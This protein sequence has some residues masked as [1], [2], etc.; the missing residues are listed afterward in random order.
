MA[1]LEVRSHNR[2]APLSVLKY[3]SPRHRS[4]HWHSFELPRADY[5]E[6]CEAASRGGMRIAVI[7]MQF[8]VPSE[9]FASNDVRELRKRGAE[10]EVHCLR[11]AHPQA[12][13][14]LEERELH[15]LRVEHNDFAVGLRGFLYALGRPGLLAR[16]VRWLIGCSWRKPAQLTKALGLLPRAFAILRGLGETRPDV[17]H[18]AWGHYPALVGYLVQQHSPGT[19]TSLSLAA[20][21]LTAE[22]GGSIEVA[23]RADFVR[24]L[25]HCNVPD[26]VRFT[27]VSP[28][29]VE[30][31]YDGIDLARIERI[32]SEQARVPRRISVA[33]RLIASKR[34]DDAIAI[35]ASLHRRWPESTLVVMGD[36]PERQRLEALCR[37]LGLAEAVEFLG[38]V[39]HERAIRQLA[40]SEVTLLTSAKASERLPNAVKEGMACGCICVVSD[41]PGIAELVRHG[42]SGFVVPPGRAGEAEEAIEAVFSR[43]VDVAAIADRA[44]RHVRERFDL[45]SSADRYVELWTATLQARRGLVSAATE[46][47]GLRETDAMRA[48]GAQ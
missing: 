30:V 24:T 18:I 14:M 31:I 17:V 1:F 9:T 47:P 34:V 37:D 15:G 20:Y 26:V 38:H 21:D 28:Q 42:L 19:A 45:A 12:A 33:S 13:E 5:V 4:I 29:R 10:V 46:P 6:G 44:R 8:P 27:G 2:P 22:F 36:G 7:T 25:A 43:E 48:G 41:S 40:R 16:T 35:F 32:A 39:S 3:C 23:Q 11:A